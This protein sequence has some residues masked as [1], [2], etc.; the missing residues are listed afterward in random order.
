MAVSSPLGACTATGC[1]TKRVCNCAARRVVVRWPRRP[2]SRWCRTGVDRSPAACCSLADG[3]RVL[4]T[5]AHAGSSL[6]LDRG[7]NLDEPHLTEARI[8]AVE[9]LGSE[10]VAPTVPGAHVV[11]DRHLHWT[12]SVNLGR[13]NV[14]RF[15]LFSILL[16]YGSPTTSTRSCCA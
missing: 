9:H 13:V 6:I 12:D 16:P 11:I 3:D 8:V 4:R 14:Q 2:R 1:C 5:V 15:G 10:H 7:R